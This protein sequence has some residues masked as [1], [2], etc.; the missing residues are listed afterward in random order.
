M[1]LAFT[2]ILSVSAISASDVNSQTNG[3]VDDQSD[4]SIDDDAS[5]ISIDDD[6]SD[7]STD[8]NVEPNSKVIETDDMDLSTNSDIDSIVEVYSEN[9]IS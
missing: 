5:H 3:L 2:V 8:D 1:L 6:Q 4:I 9:I 7:I